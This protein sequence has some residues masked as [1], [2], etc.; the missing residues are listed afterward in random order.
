MPGLERKLIS[1]EPVTVEPESFVQ[2]RSSSELLQLCAVIFDFLLVGAVAMATHLGVIWRNGPDYLNLQDTISIGA[3]AGVLS[4]L[5]MAIAGGYR[6]SALRSPRLQSIR[7]TQAWVATFFGL[8]WAAFLLKST[9]SFPRSMVTLFFLFGWLALLASHAAAAQWLRSALR[10]RKLSLQ[11]ICL[12]GTFDGTEGEAL[13]SRL[14]A[15]G[16]EVVGLCPVGP[17]IAN[18]S[19][20]SR[21][22]LSAAKI[23]RMALGTTRV[24]AIYLFMP[25]RNRRQMD[26][27][28]AAL[29]HLPV[30]V[31]L[32]ADQSTAEFLSRPNLRFGEFHGFE[33]QRAPLTKTDRFLKRGLDIIVA[34]GALIVLSPLLLMSAIGIL[35]ETGRPIIFRQSRRGFGGRPFNIL[36]FRSMTVQENGPIIRQ[37]G[38]NDPRISPLGRVLRRTSIDEL[39]QFINVLRGDMSIVGPRP[40]AI[41]HD[42]LYDRAIAS[43]AF[44]HHVKPGI[45]GWAQVNGYRG[46]TKE[47]AQMEARV[48]HDIWYINNWSIWLDLRVILM[49]L[50]VIWNDE[51]AF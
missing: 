15:H 35:L 17:T 8:A 36:K 45:T 12:V 1:A 42:N 40:H 50:L 31:V 28:R 19:D 51:N 43:Y 11:R 6:L 3:L 20:F 39:P 38:R 37:A 13:Q 48:E 32:F 14:V 34:L 2:L 29:A 9:A 5:T 4:C 27:M 25:W 21:A 47:L 44:R 10:E 18:G 22:C 41:A 23:V 49:T 46:E 26:E 7:V 30:P 24:D 16:I 33:L